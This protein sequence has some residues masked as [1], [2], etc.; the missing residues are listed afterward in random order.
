M[1]DYPKPSDPISCNFEYNYRLNN[2]D[3]LQIN[4]YEFTIITDMSVTVTSVS[5]YSKSTGVRETVL[6]EI[7]YQEVF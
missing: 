2:E 7:G 5:T 1:V 3:A 6:I 4:D